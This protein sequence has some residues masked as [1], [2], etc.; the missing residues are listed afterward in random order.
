MRSYLL[1]NFVSLALAV[2]VIQ[3]NDDGWAENN[4]RTF[5]NVLDKAGYQVVLSGPAENQSGT[6]MFHF[7]T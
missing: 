4:A 7:F 3:S 6:G 5:F 2:R 1:L